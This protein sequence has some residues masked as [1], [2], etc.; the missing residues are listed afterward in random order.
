MLRVAAVAHLI[1]AS[2]K[3]LGEVDIDRVTRTMLVHDAAKIV[4]FDLRKEPQLRSIQ[5]NFIKIYGADEEI[6]LMKIVAELGLEEKGRFI[7]RQM[8]LINLQNQIPQKEWELKAAW[9]A[10]FRVAPTGVM[11]TDA[12][13]DELIKRQKSRGAALQEIQRLEGIKEYCRILEKELQQKVKIDLSSIN[14]AVIQSVTEQFKQLT[15]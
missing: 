9:Y 15:Y 8:P 6:A 10:D 7:L 11:S 4:N 3:E 5:A 1:C 14:D 2:W 13:L 12:R